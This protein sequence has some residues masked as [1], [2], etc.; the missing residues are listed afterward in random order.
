MGEIFAER[1][2]KEREAT[3]SS[4]G[5]RRELPRFFVRP[6]A[7]SGGGSEPG[8]SPPNSSSSIS[9]TNKDSESTVRAES[10]GGDG[11]RALFFGSRRG[12]QDLVVEFNSLLLFSDSL[13]LLDL[14]WRP[15]VQ[16]QGLWR[17]F[18]FRKESSRKPSFHSYFDCLCAP[19]E[20]NCSS[21]RPPDRTS[22][23]VDVQVLPTDLGCPVVH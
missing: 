7:V 2:R 11:V 10:G 14:Q 5:R 13:R 8:R 23:L 3:C 15:Q 9:S 20:Y 19:A 6:P 17:R 21:F 1:R 18:H 12:W 16:Q 4:N 22:V